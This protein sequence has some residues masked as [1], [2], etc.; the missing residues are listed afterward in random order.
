MSAHV[1]A[2]VVDVR[3]PASSSLKE[4]RSIVQ[5]MLAGARRRFEVASAETG[6]QDHV[7]RAELTFVAA[8]GSATHTTEIIDSVDRFVWSFP[9]IEVVDHDRHWLEVDR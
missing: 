4:K 1:L 9:E 7:D 5:S 6:V 2:L 3:I 8:S